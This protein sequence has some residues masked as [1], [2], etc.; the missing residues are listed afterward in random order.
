MTIAIV[1][2]PNLNMLGKRDPNHYGALTLDKIN[3][4]IDDKFHNVDFIFYQSNHEG[5][6]IDFLQTATFDALIINPG[7][8]THTSIALRDALESI[9]ALKVEVHLSNIYEREA[10]RHINYI[11]DVVNHSIYGKKEQS[12][13]EAVTYILEKLS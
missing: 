3:E 4:M 10:F 11:K 1:N 9:E 5:Y 8:Y 13:I 12:Y 6:L 2:G 7:A